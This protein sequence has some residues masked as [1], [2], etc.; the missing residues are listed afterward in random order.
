MHCSRVPGLVFVCVYVCGTASLNLPSVLLKAK[1]LPTWSLVMFN[2]Q[3]L[4]KVL[5]LSAESR[6]S[7]NVQKIQQQ[8]NHKKINTL[9]EQ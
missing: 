7:H 9:S 1:C 5:S 6:L 8:V 3:P 4:H 2:K